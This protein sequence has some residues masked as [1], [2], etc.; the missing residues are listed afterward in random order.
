MPYYIMLTRMVNI[1]LYKVQLILHYLSGLV[2]RSVSFEM[3]EMPRRG[4]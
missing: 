3:V 2:V 1:F 4:G